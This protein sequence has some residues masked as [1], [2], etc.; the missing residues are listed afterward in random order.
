MHSSC[1][2]FP[3]FTDATSHTSAGMWCLQYLLPDVNNLPLTGGNV[4]ISQRPGLLL[5]VQNTAVITGGTMGSRWPWFSSR[6]CEQKE[7]RKP[8][9]LSGLLDTVKYVPV[10]QE[11]ALWEY[12]V[13]SSQQCRAWVWGQGSALPDGKSARVSL[14]V[15]QGPQSKDLCVVHAGASSQGSPQW[16]SQPP[17]S[18]GCVLQLGWS[19]RAQGGA[20]QSLDGLHLHGQLLLRQGWRRKGGPGQPSPVWVLGSMSPWLGLF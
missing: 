17:S 1:K 9:G 5:R 3:R 2:T 6:M 8:A 20:G 14:L 4:C 7:L 18:P 12:T 19:T 10:S 16:W 15:W 13:V 11:G